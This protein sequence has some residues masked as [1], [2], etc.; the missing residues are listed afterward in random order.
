LNI[1]IGWED[2]VLNGFDEVTFGVFISNYW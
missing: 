2:H 1:F